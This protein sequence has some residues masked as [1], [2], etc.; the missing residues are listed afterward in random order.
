MPHLFHI[1]Y[2]LSGFGL[3]LR[4]PVSVPD[5]NYDQKL[6]EF[7]SEFEITPHHMAWGNDRI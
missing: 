3:V 7:G 6:T 2:E 5:Q 1:R 4:C